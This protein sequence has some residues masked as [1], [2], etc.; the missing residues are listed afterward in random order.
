M[1]REPSADTQPTLQLMNS[2][3]HE[4]LHL[5]GGLAE[6]RTGSLLLV[7]DPALSLGVQTWHQCKVVWVDGMAPP[8]ARLP[9]AT[10]SVE[11]QG[12]EE[13]SLLGS[14][15]PPPPPPAELQ[16]HFKPLTGEVCIAESPPTVDCQQGKDGARA[17]ALQAPRVLLAERQQ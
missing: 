4:H 5:W 7:S 13:V 2:Q 11:D 9:E 6:A 15:A 17:P 12:G 3:P 10:A 16:C 8:L 14:L 1:L